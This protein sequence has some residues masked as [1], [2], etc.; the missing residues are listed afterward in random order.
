MLALGLAWTAPAQI[1]TLRIV[2]YNIEADI[3]GYTTPRPGLITPSAGG[4]AQVNNLPKRPAFT[5]TGAS[6][7]S[8][9]F[10]PVRERSL[11]CVSTST[12]RTLRMSN[13]K[14]S[15]PPPGRQ[16]ERP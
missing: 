14:Q 11:C 4:T 2:T 9:R 1:L 7:T 5:L 3:N 6:K 10:A 12:P 8:S 13:S 16:R 15:R